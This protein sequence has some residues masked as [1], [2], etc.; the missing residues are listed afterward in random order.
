MKSEVIAVDAPR[1]LVIT[2]NNTGNVTFDLVPLGEG[3]LLTVTH[4]G[5][6]TR[7]ALIGH[8][9]GWHA[10]LDV[11]ENLAFARPPKPFWPRWQELRGEYGER[12]P[13]DL[14]A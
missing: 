7:S 5:F 9:A 2:W 12:L 6:R 4:A 13:A 11:L 14:G 3:V 1:K 8:S 10:H